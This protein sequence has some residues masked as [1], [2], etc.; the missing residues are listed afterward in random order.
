MKDFQVDELLYSAQAEQMVAVEI[1]LTDKLDS[2]GD[3][4]DDPDALQV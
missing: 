1:E 4:V 2:D 3:A